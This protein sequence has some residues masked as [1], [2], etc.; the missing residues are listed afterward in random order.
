MSQLTEERMLDSGEK[1][2]VLDV[3]TQD[4]E[5]NMGPQHPATHGVLRVVLTADGE[6]LTSADPHV[7]Y[8][9]RCAEKV[10][11]NV[12]FD[13]YIPYTDRYDY[14]SAMNNNVGFAL[15]VEK[16][17]GLE[18]PPRATWLRMIVSE[19]N[20]VASHLL[21]FGTYGIDIGAIT[22]FLYGFREREWVLSLFEKICGARLTY[23][24]AFPGGVINDAP[25]GWFDEVLKFCDVFDR[26][27]REY[28]DLLT[29]NKIFIERTKD[30]GSVTADQ[31]R[32]F[33][34]TGPCLRGSGVRYDLREAQ[35]YLFYDQVGFDVPIGRG[36]M[37]T[38]GDCWDRYWVRM[39][40]MLQSTRI[41]REC[42]ERCIKDTTPGEV[43]AKKPKT[44]K[45]AANEAYV[46]IEN[47][48]GELGHYL[49][50][51]GGAQCFR[52]KVRGPSFTNVS[53]LAKLLPGTML[54]DAVAIIGSIDIVL[55]EVDR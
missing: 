41:V 22:P 30:V 45:V 32:E 18:V 27:W 53:C 7:G 44:L 54:A 12:D 3:R 36:E 20:R 38:V 14:L 25:G 17:S 13:G 16:A 2:L 33:G 29:R 19:L 9:H 47:P 10:G 52:I 48:R 5:I 1:E 40:E 26:K 50:T 11:E 37:G 46:G 34:W 15:V 23:S 31:A 49:V 43:M 21:A 39:A 8:I 55:G 6:I 42:V 35:P 4:M 24:Y 28:D 51:D